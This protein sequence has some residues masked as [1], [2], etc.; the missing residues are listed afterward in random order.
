[1]GP[2]AMGVLFWISDAAEVATV[3]RP[4]DEDDNDDDGE[5]ATRQPRDN[6][7]YATP[8]VCMSAACVHALIPWRSPT[9]VLLEL[10]GLAIGLACAG[11]CLNRLN[12]DPTARSSID[13]DENII[14]SKT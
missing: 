11:A 3:P 6:D 9:R 10:N 5:P 8:M 1:M 12:G 14:F 7:N 13:L 4:N 2:K